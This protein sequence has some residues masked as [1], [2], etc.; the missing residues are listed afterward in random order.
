MQTTLYCY[1]VGP[2]DFWP[3]AMTRKQLAESLVVEGQTHISVSEL[4]MDAEHASR[5]I[6]WDG[7]HRQEP[8]FFVLPDPENFTM[9]LGFVIKQDNDGLCFVVSPFPLQHL[10]DDCTSHIL[11]TFNKKDTP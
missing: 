4:L 11:M 7:D 10:H 2:V 1:A 6:G 3:G 9:A 5:K 8:R